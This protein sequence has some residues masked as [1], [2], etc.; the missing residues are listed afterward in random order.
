MAEKNKAYVLKIVKERD[1]KFIAN[2]EIEWDWYR[3]H[4]SRY[5]IDKYLS[6]L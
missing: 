6:V 5:E 4:I 2:K 3:T 1:V